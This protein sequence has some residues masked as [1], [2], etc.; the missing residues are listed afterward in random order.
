VVRRLLAELNLVLKLHVLP[1]GLGKAKA[2]A[3]EDKVGSHDA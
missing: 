1:N 2:S 3:L